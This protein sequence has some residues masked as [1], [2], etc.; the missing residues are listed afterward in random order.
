MR[1]KSMRENDGE[2]T[3]LDRA[4]NLIQKMGMVVYL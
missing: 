4:F 3:L 1:N 2:K